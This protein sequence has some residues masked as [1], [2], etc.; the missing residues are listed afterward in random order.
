MRATSQ[1]NSKVAP[2]R[3]VDGSASGLDAELRQRVRHRTVAKQGVRAEIEQPA[4]ASSAA[5]VSPP[6]PAPITYTT[7]QFFSGTVSYWPVADTSIA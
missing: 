4:R 2:R 6:M 3:F 5:L 7:L 1:P